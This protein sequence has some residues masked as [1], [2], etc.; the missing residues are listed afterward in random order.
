MPKNK[1][2]NL[3]RL[4]AQ[5][6]IDKPPVVLAAQPFDGA[7]SRLPH[8]PCRGNIAPR[9]TNLRKVCCAATSNSRYFMDY[10]TPVNPDE[11]SASFPGRGESAGRNEALNK[12]GSRRITKQARE[13]RGATLAAQRFQCPCTICIIWPRILG[14][15]ART[16]PLSRNWSLPSKSLTNP[17]A[18]MM[19]SAPPAMSQAESPISQNPS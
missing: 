3:R 17:P 6:A 1:A 7:R 2:G 12:R 18:S 8:L 15:A 16:L 11:I 10:P 13:F 19:R 4:R 9:L 5:Q 14:L